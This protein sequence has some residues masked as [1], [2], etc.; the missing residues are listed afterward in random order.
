MLYAV[1][2]I[3]L[4]M[5][6]ILLALQVNNWNEEQK[7]R[8][9]EKEVLKD[10]LTN[11]ERNNAI[12]HESLLLLE[13]FDKSSEIVLETLRNNLPYSDTLP[14]HFFSATRT[15]G[16]LFPVS[17]E[18]YESLKNAGFDIIHSNFLK[19]K[20]LQIFEISYKRIKSKAHWTLNSSNSQIDYAQSLFRQETGEI[21]VPV[22]FDQLKKD[23]RFYSIL[24]EIKESKRGFLKEDIMN[25]LHESDTV[26]KLL[27]NELKNLH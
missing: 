1:G 7:V 23:N 9:K 19:D 27:K 22:N 17:V 14:K 4:V 18:G 26:I 11:L 3:V 20:I 13:D 2:E 24:M 5:I 21:L 12:I 15:G 10:I 6:G 16:L 25:S 8:V